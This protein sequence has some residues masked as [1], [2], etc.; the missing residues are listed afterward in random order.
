MSAYVVELRE[1][2]VESDVSVQCSRPDER[3]DDLLLQLRR[4]GLAC[5]AAMRADAGSSA[6]VN[7]LVCDSIQSI[8]LSRIISVSG[9]AAVAVLC[10]EA[11]E[12][13]RVLS[14]ELGADEVMLWSQ[15]PRERLARIRALLRRSGRQAAPRSSSSW[16][17]HPARRQ[18]TAP[19]GETYNVTSHEADIL[20]ELSR[21]DGHSASRAR[22][23]AR[24]GALGGSDRNV[25]GIISRL[26]R[27]ITGS[28]PRLISTLRGHGYCLA[29]P[30]EL[31]GGDA[32]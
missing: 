31:I 12:V 27:K 10:D 4:G 29:A 23:A 30:L 14:L 7:L 20:M 6:R 25:D 24:L 32:R 1:P 17:F 5:G 3:I 16:S 26:R 11:D 21:S 15:G 13:D 2:S 18:L 28:A 22:L 8:D 9:G 19:G